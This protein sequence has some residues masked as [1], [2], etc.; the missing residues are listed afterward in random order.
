[1]IF[2]LEL[3]QYSNEFDAII[4]ITCN[5]NIQEEMSLWGSGKPHGIIYH[6]GRHANSGHYTRCIR[7]NEKWYTISDS[8]VTT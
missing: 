4:K 8:L 1:M 6:Q 7:S 5:L 3:F 2:H